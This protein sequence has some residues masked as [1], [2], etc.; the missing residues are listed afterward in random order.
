MTR[1]TIGVL[2][3]AL[4]LTVTFAPTL[5]GQVAEGL[6]DPN[7]ASRDELLSLPHMNDALVDG[8][9]TARPFSGAVALNAFLL[10]QSL[11]PEQLEDVYRK[12]F[13]HIDLNT[14]S[15]EE[16]QLIP[17]VGRRM[18]HEFDEYRPWKTF[19]QFDKEIGKYVDDGEVA[20]LKSY[21]FIPLDLN[22]AS[23]AQ[24]MTIPGVGKRMAH[25]LEEYRPWKSQKQFQKEIGKYVDDKEVA[26]L[27]RYV[28]IGT[29]E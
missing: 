22:T 15:S 3:T 20:R 9:I 19:A 1:K 29:G 24:F 16:M 17:G 4:A 12:A 18:A 13:I 14:A 27:W 11:K 7:V 28:V 5:Q 8:L 25:E 21:C 10:G 26:R 6:I 23:E 2:A